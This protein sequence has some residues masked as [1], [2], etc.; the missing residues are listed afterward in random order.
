M[1]LRSGLF[2]VIILLVLS[3]II[4]GS[5]VSAAGTYPLASSSDVIQ[6]ALDFLESQQASDGSIGS[7]TDS[8]W[9]CIAIAAAGEDPNSWDQGGD[10]L[11]EYLRDNPDYEGAFNLATAYARTILAALASGEDPSSFGTYTGGGVVNGDFVQAV[12]DLYNGTQFEDGFDSTDLVND[13]MWAV[14]ALLAAGESVDSPEV[15]GGLAFIAAN[16]DANGGWSW[17]VP[18][19]ASYA[20]SPDDTAVALLSLLKGGYAPD[21]S[22]VE[23]GLSYLK[24]VQDSTGGFVSY[25]YDN[26]SSTAWAVNAIAA[27]R[28]NP[29]AS[30]WAS[31]PTPVDYLLGQQQSDGRFPYRDPLPDGY[32]ELPVQNTAWAVEAL[33]GAH[34]RAPAAATVVG[35]VAESPHAAELLLPWIACAVGAVLL[36]GWRVRRSRS[37]TT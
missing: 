4:S 27:A 12:N 3:P 22:V 19:H 15:A 32:S 18:G 29:V 25:G 37:A 11:V 5:V 35:G 23:A 16:Q 24:S 10:S 8:G 31:S 7:Y 9:A 36:I 28:Q 6:D 20:T 21:S 34:Y 17:A 30:E 13:D 33:V 1:K 26:V 2:A 14:R